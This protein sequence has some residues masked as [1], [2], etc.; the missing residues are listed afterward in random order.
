MSDGDGGAVYCNSSE[1]TRLSGRFAYNTAKGS[2][3]AICVCGDLVNLFD[4]YVTDNN[5]TGHGCGIYVDELY[6][7]NV[8][9]LVVVRDNLRSDKSRDDVFLDAF[10]LTEAKINVGGLEEGSQIW[11][12][13]PDSDHTVSD[14]VSEYQKKYFYSDFSSSN[15]KKFS[16]EADEAK[17]ENNVLITSA[18]GSG[19]LVFITIA[20]AV[21][22]AAFIVLAAVFGKRK[23]G[24][25]N[26]D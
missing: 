9:G 7:L 12:L 15:S 25:N 21:F 26:E 10:A 17:T 5:A 3:G 1:G 6:D 23:K 20:L 4:A 18:I 19:S 24:E 14:N 22:I 13:T 8:Q 16:F 11:V 2:G